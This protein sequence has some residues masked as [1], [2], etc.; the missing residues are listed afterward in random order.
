MRG[1]GERF[2][3]LIVPDHRTPLAIRTH[4]SDPVPYVI[5]DS[6][7]E[8]P[9]DVAKAFNEKSA[10]ASGNHFEDGYLMTDYFFGK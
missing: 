8:T 3:V 1:T 4:S 2:K 7:A 5:Y 6:G 10:Y 9:V